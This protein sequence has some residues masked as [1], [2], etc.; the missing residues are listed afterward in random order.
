MTEKKENISKYVEQTSQLLGLN[1]TSEYLSG[2]IDNFERI[3]AIASLVTE[4]DLPEDIEAAATF[5][6]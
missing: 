2:V 4:F 3:S 6:P 1:L 5:E